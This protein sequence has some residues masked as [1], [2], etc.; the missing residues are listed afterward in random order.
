MDVWAGIVVS[1]LL[2]A[3]GIFLSLRKQPAEIRSLDHSALKNS[4]E[5]ND[6]LSEQ[7]LHLQERVD[8]L[9]KTSRG[10][11]RLTVEFSTGENPKIHKAELVVI[12]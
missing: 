11:F 7:V 5:V 8:T 3:A 9:E 2:G 1:L 10:P 4:T 6:M 12:R